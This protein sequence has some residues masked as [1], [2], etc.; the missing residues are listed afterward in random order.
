M[1][2]KQL[3]PGW[4]T[5]E[6]IGSGGFGK[7]YKIEKVDVSGSFASAL[8]VISIP[9]SSD[10]YRSY[11]DDGYD[12]ESITTI[13]RNQL[14]DIVSEFSLMSQFKG[15][16]N[17]VS[18]EDHMIVEHEDARGWD[19]YIKM[20]LL[21]SLPKYCNA[22]YGKTCSM[23]EADAIKL[24]KDLCAAL[25]LCE[26]KN[27]IH[28][29]IKPQNI[30]VN[31]YGSFKLGDFGIART[32]E[33]TTRA[34]KIGTYNY[35]APEVYTGKAY[36][37][38]ADI[39]SLGL[40]LYWLMNDR[41]LPFLPT[42]RVPT[43]GEANEAQ[44]KRLAG[45]ALPAPKNASPGFWEIIRRACL[46]EPSERFAAAGEMLSALE[47]LGGPGP[48]RAK[49]DEAE[50]FAGDSDA[51][52]GFFDGW[53]RP[54]RASDGNA[55]NG[56]GSK[57]Y[58]CK[59]CGTPV[60]QYNSYCAKC[61]KE[62]T[63]NGGS[64]APRGK[65]PFTEGTGFGFDSDYRCPCCNKPMQSPDSICNECSK[66]LDELQIGAKISFSD[67]T[68][69]SRDR[70]RYVYDSAAQ[71]PVRVWAE[72]PNGQQIKLYPL[73]CPQCGGR[74]KQMYIYAGHGYYEADC[75]LCGGTGVFSG[76]HQDWKK[77]KKKDEGLRA[78]AREKGKVAEN[79]PV[80]LG[81]GYVHH[82]SRSG[83]LLPM[84]TSQDVRCPKC[85]GKK[86]K[87]IE[88]P[89]EH[90]KY[91]AKQIVDY[92]PWDIWDPETDGEEKVLQRTGAKASKRSDT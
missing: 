60:D 3:W 5:V 15:E 77:Y 56:S 44:A 27:V 28:R 72:R 64:S 78:W 42:D 18:Y 54:G 90:E 49:D 4:N 39:Y 46:P 67:G 35:M 30:F 23:P 75:G 16:S 66:K 86:I 92:Y 36:H 24:A 34:T 80:C 88:K 41:R 19:I 26:K 51:T 33:H 12:D 37:S 58:K 9:A 79:C 52:L 21:T 17:I 31:E 76:T 70:F 1:G 89:A 38:T 73:D 29:D 50:S 61:A 22:K 82:F 10:E 40:V 20:E 48:V 57:K 55:G 84:T 81:R 59:K 83:I 53:A 32:M 74:K 43:A 8:K 68:T 6:E 62:E 69:I 13:F 25:M 47:Q 65:S 87:C 45:E 14:D 71:R 85:Q 91:F 7:V 11:E 63:G 2:E